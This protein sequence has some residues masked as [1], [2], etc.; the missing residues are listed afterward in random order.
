MSMSQKQ[1]LFIREPTLEDEKMFLSA[2]QRSHS[3]HHPWVKSPQTP[4]EFSD[5]LQRFQQ[6]NQKSFLICDHSGDIAGVFNISEIVRGLFQNAYL[7]FYAVADFSEKGYMSAGLK[8]V[9]EKV[10][11]E[12]ALH[13]LEANIQP[14]NTRSIELVK[15]NGFRYEGYSPRYLK[16]DGEWRGHE[17]WA[18]TIEDYIRNDADVLKKDHVDIVPYNPEWPT[19]A[20]QEIKKIRESLFLNKIVDIQHVGST[21]IQGVSAKPIID[22]QIAVNSLDEMKTIAIPALQKLGYEYW[23]ENPDPKR[24]FFV[25]GMPPFGE[26]RTHHVH[27]FEH[28]SDHWRNKIIFRDYLR[29]HP[30]VANDYVQLKNQLASEHMYDREKYTDEKLEFINRVLKLAQRKRGHA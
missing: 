10:F 24:M 3:L 6:Q 14:E 5:Y 22:I 30:D 13:R 11:K 15:K 20:K 17:H 18:M 9:L 26:Q 25:K 12:L 29:A 7:G 16:I 4:Q 19:M 21:A 27:I 28:D 8:L 2:M 1:K 23:F